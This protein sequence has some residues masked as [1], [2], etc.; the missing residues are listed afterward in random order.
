MNPLVPFVIGALAI[1]WLCMKEWPEW[2]KGSHDVPL[3]EPAEDY[4][5]DSHSDE[6]ADRREDAESYWLRRWEGMEP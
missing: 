5:A 4:I 6:E 3:D 2:S 1:V